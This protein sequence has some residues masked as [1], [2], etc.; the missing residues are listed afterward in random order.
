MSRSPVFQCSF[1]DNVTV[2]MTTFCK[3]GKN[4]KLD[5]ARG[6]KLACYAYEQRI[7]KSPPD[8]KEAH[9]E[10]EGVVLQ[11]YSATELNGKTEK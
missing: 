1:V 3:N 2:R 10:N 6:K 7:G 8:F 4:R 9:F 11:A 5:L